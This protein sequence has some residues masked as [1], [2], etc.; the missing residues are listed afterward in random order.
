M[1]FT[2]ANMLSFDECVNKS[3]NK[4]SAKA[5]DELFVRNIL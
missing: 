1:S 3:G 5:I 4:L 2:N